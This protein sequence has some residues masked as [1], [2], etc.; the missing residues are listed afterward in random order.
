[1]ELDELVRERDAVALCPLATWR[2][3]P[4]A[5]VLVPEES[6]WTNEGHMHERARRHPM[7]PRARPLQL[8]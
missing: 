8:A 6:V 7:K 4:L 5:H 1:M 3:Q 2:T